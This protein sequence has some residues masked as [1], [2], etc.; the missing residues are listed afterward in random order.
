MRQDQLSRLEEL[1]ERLAD[2]FL[3]EADPENWS[4]GG[5]LPQDMS[6]TER[7]DRHWDRKGAMGTGGVLRYTLD[8]ISSGKTN[9]TGDQEVQTE[10]DADLDHK[11]REA[12]KRAAKAVNRVLDKAKK[13]SFD[14]AIHGTKS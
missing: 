6:K 11:I 3:V 5:K 7:G 8:L 14:K 9:Q 4:G 1:A 12:E 13:D 10:R 2:T